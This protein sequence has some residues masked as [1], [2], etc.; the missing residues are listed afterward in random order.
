MVH[1]LKFCARGQWL[2]H[3]TLIPALHPGVSQP[4]HLKPPGL[5]SHGFSPLPSATG[6]C[7]CPATAPHVITLHSQVRCVSGRWRPLMEGTLASWVC[8]AL[9]PFP[10]GKTAP[11][12]FLSHS[13]WRMGWQFLHG[14][15]WHAHCSDHFAPFLGKSA[16]R[17]QHA[18]GK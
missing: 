11:I 8:W 2:I 9:K 5:S 16:Y 15:L 12:H 4:H 3:F 18:F 7:C 14:S 6:E 10:G 13:C 1:H 17:W